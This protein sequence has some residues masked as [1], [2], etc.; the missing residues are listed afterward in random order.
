VLS[1]VGEEVTAVLTAIHEGNGVRSGL[2]VAPQIAFSQQAD[3]AHAMRNLIGGLLQAAESAKLVDLFLWSDMAGLVDAR[4]HE[5]RNEG[6]VM[7]D[8]SRGP[9][10]LFRK[11]SANK[12][13]AIKQ[14]I[15]YGV[16]I[17][18]AESRGDISEYYAVYVDWSRRKLLPVI[19]ED[20]FQ[21]TVA[22]R[23]S[24]R[25]FLARH[26]GRV[27]AGIVV[28]FFPGSVME[29]AAN[30]SLTDALCLRPNDLL[31]WRAIEWGCSEGMTKYNLGGSHF[32]LRRF[33][34]ELVPTTRHRLDLTVFQRYA[35]GDWIVGTVEKTRPFIPPRMVEFGRSM[36]GRFR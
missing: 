22:L 9:E 26:N 16:S 29:Y 21:E 23:G 8:L 35:I 20:Q 19:D 2:S 12:K 3:R 6:V 17:A 25:V 18:Q 10:A 34:G 14:A 27:I 24:R 32:F 1:V 7:L 4:F 15:R 33:G 11:F 13:A 5:K 30:S 28:R 36:R 31:N